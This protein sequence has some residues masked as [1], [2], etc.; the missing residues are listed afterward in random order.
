MMRRTAA[1]VALLWSLGAT[2]QDVKAQEMKAEVIHWW[3]SGGESAAVKVIADQF[4][5]AGG[6]WIDN[7]IAGGVNARASAINRTIGGDPPTAMQ[8]NTG[9]Q[10]D[11]LV[12]GNLLVDV[13]AMADEGRWRSVIPEAIIK[14]TTRGGKMYAV[15][16]NIHGQNWLFYN[17]AVLEKAGA[18]EPTNWTDVFAA[19]DKIKAAGLIPLAF[20]GTKTWERNLF[21]AVLAGQGG[22][23]MF[24]G[25][26]GSRNAAIAAS[27]DFK[28]VAETY[29]KLR[30]YVDVGSP[31]RNW[32]DATNLV[33]QGKA[34]MQ[35]MGDWAKGEFVA[36]GQTAGK[37]F[38]C[39]VLSNKGGGYVMG[40]DVF[41]FPK[42]K[43]PAGAKAQLMLAKIML[44]PQTQIQFAQKKGSIPVRLDLDVSSLDLCAQKAVKWLAD[45]SQQIPAQE[46]LSPP[47]LTG[48]M[49][50]AISQYWNTPSMTA[51]A[52][53]AKVAGILKA[54][55]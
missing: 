37:E 28:A 1:A 31:G 55:Y 16:I 25:I 12:E 19:L 52:F 17:K 46:M 32:N 26:Y 27:P 50:D 3:T 36:A 51:D 41:A 14:A 22:A 48:A 13:D 8:F 47:D 5:K 42:L 43:D 40:G 33:I 21:N 38:G 44:D 35:V 9:K 23:A 34:G 29:A 45:K 7:A 2:T 30:S 10:F 53:T 49:E 24:E 11:E 54:V 15:P 20:S 18:T 4:K 39:T 6:V